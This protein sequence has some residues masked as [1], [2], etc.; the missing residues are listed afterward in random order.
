MIKVM[1]QGH[2]AFRVADLDRS[3]K[4]YIDHFGLHVMEE[5]TEE[6]VVFLGLRDQGH[7]V[8]LVQ[9]VDADASKPHDKMP[10]SG[11]GFHHI[12]FELE[13]EAEL[14]AAYLRLKEHNVPIIAQMDH[15]SQQSVYFNDPDGNILEVYWQQPNAIEMFANGRADEDRPLTFE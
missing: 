15:G 6:H 10:P 12:G 5:N 7:F 2:I 3:K 1:R 9:S 11:T 8:D 4:F 14:R 13:T